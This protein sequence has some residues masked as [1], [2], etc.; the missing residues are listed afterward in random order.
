MTT[1][2]GESVD[3]IAK[4]L[5]GTARAIGALRVGDVA[6]VVE[7]LVDARSRRATVFLLGNGGSA[8]TASHMMNDLTKMTRHD[9]A[10]PFR[11]IALTD[12]VPL[13]T[14]WANDDDYAAMFVRQLESLLEPTDVVLAV[15]TS[16]NS[17]NVVRALEY[18]RERGAATIGFTGQDGGHMRELVDVCVYT[19]TDN[20]GQQEDA[21]LALAHAVAFAVRDR[22]RHA[23]AYA[24]TGSR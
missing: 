18:A 21:H 8:A 19:P 20:I 12:C 15:S 17:P 7:V 24:D 4:Y 1:A 2:V 23:G 13:M 16:G 14:A 6:Q 5:D 11:A 9:G 22:A 10:P 3:P